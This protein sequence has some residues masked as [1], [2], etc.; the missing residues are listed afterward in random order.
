MTQLSEKKGFFGL[1]K[2]K[3]QIVWG[4]DEKTTLGESDIK[5][6]VD[7]YLDKRD[8]MLRE[9]RKAMTPMTQ[10]DAEESAIPEAVSQNLFNF[11]SMHA[12]GLRGNRV[13]GV[14][15]FSDDNDIMN[16][17]VI[18]AADN[19][20]PDV[21]ENKKPPQ[22]LE[23]KPADVVN[24]LEH[25]PIPFNME[26]IDHKIEMLKRKKALVPG[27]F[28]IGID[29][30][31]TIERLEN[32]KKYPEYKEFFDKFPYT[33]TDK[34]DK[35]LGKYKLVIEATEFFIPHFPDEAIEVMEL[36][37]AKTKEATGKCPVYYVIAEQKDFKKREAAYKPKPRDPILLVQS[38]FGYY[39][40]ILG[41]WDKEMILLGEL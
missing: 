36:Y 5:T 18:P 39:W 23:A 8:E 40:Q 32:R 7:T 26:E 29:I 21:S 20:S 3:L 37:T 34:I 33:S 19:P 35:L 16:G 13:G 25:I 28:Q 15:G 1:F 22:K 6:I 30:D 24:E 38:P 41:A 27:N 12:E 9:E 4:G 10:R 14:I 17:S 11:F 2:K 31:G